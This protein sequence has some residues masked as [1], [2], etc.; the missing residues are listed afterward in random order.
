LSMDHLGPSVLHVAHAM[1]KLN[2]AG[3]ALISEQLGWTG[4]DLSGVTRKVPHNSFFVEC[5]GSCIARR[6]DQPT[7]PLLRLPQPGRA[8]T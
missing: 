3:V 6:G 5:I 8:F 7:N 1:A 4:T 2:A